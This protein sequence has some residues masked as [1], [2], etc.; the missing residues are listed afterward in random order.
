MYGQETKD[1]ILQRLST[2]ESLRAICRDDGMPDFA[3][4]KRWAADDEVF[5]AQYVRARE[6]GTEAE[7]EAL[8]DLQEELPERTPQGSVDTGWV[9]WKR[10]Q[11]DTKKWALSKKA[12]KKYGEKIEATHEAGESITGIVRKI[13]RGD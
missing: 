12:P 3:T 2:G 6:E 5:R 10:L 7:F 9:A 8:E 1:L 13:M 4:V 11:I